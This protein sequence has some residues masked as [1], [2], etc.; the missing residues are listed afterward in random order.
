[1]P[2]TSGSE[3]AASDTDAAG[4][5]SM[6]EG[7]HPFRGRS[8][9]SQAAVLLGG[10]LVWF[11]AYAASV[12]TLGGA[13]AATAAAADAVVARRNA[14]ALASAA[15][16]LYFGA[17]WTRAHGGPLLNVVYVLGVQVFV[18][19][20]AYALGGTPPEHVLSAADSSFVLLL[21]D[22]AWILHRAVTI[23]PGF[24]VF[25]LV[26]AVWGATLSP[27]EQDAFVESHLPEAWLDLRE[28]E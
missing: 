19:G 12:T 7:F 24:A 13:A 5:F 18:P 11:V 10:F 2:E 21:A 20:R 6:T 22:P 1:M 8:R 15:T 4:E 14:A 9:R 23:L 17:L 3:P 27:D 25:A 16:G 26:L 28:T